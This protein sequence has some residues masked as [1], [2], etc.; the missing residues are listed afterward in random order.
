[1]TM[2]KKHLLAI[3][4]FAATFLNSNL[5]KA[6]GLAVNNTNATSNNSAML[7]VSST[8]QGMLI[9]RMTASQRGLIGTPATGLLVYQTDGTTGFYYYSGSVWVNITSAA[10]AAGGDLTGTYPSPTLATSGVTAGAYG[11]ATSVPTYTVDAKG[12]ITAATNTTITGVTPGGTASGDLTGSYP[13]PT[14]ATG[15]VTSTKIL[16][17]AI[18][19]I[20][21]NTAAAIAYS[22]LSLGSSIALTDLSATGTRNSTTYL[23]GDNTW[24]T[25]SGGG[26]I[27]QVS[28]GSAGSSSTTLALGGSQTLFTA[29]VTSSTVT[30]TISYTISNQLGHTVLTNSLSTSG[31]PAFGP[32]DPL[33][34]ANNGGTASSTTFYRGDGQ[35][36]TPSGGASFGNSTIVTTGTSYTMANTDGIVTLTTTGSS[37]TVTL[38]NASTCSS[39]PYYF[40]LPATSV[41]GG[42]TINVAVTGGNTI[43]D[44]VSGG[45][46]TT[47]QSLTSSAC[48]VILY[49]ISSTQWVILNWY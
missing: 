44:I 8:T 13:G 49:P 28:M 34:L 41:S 2:I 38:P 20:D 17:G 10:T 14:I 45:F 36:Q 43:E 12:R 24:A 37:H 30:P 46:T 22:K 48:A 15:A 9:P 32:L 5:A 33:A 4:L 11:S 31:A 18:A 26:G 3:A 27:S 1:M 6:Q 23:R 40:C 39:R 16:D 29:S 35:W 21:V 42:T 7:D 19:N 25:V 47:T